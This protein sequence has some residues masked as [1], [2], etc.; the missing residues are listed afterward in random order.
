M[1]PIPIVVVIFIKAKPRVRKYWEQNRIKENKMIS[2][3]SDTLEGFRVVK[4]FSGSKKEVKKFEKVSS[5]VKKAF[6][7][8]RH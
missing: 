4:V 7:R 5:D 8:Q 6:T 3:V 2:M 1:I